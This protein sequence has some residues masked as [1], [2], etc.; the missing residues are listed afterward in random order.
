MAT[1]EHLIERDLISKLEDLRY[2]YRADIRDRAAMEKNFREKFQALNRVLLP[3]VR[4]R[5]YPAHLPA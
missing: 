4:I 1:T 5:A 3:A 2:T